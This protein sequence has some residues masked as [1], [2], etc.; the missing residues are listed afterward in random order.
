MYNIGDLI[1]YGNSGVCTVE[2]IG[3][4]ESMDIPKDVIY[5][6]LLPYYRKGSTIYTPV[7]NKKVVMRPIVTKEESMRIIDEIKDIDTLWISEEKKRENEYKTAVRTCDCKQL[8]RIIKTI[9]LRKLSRIADGKK[10]TATDEKYFK[11]AEDNFYGE[12]AIPLEMT[13]EEVGKFVVAR[14]QK[15][16]DEE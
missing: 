9:Y 1:I 15:L 8:V 12:L 7:D 10:I 14:V 4:L 2:N 13:K 6:T 3:P 11:I 16:M 5:Y